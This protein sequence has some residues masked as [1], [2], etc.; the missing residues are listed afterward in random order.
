MYRPPVFR[1]DSVDA[2]RALIRDNPF[3]TLIVSGTGGLEAAHI[4]MVL[5]DDGAVG[6]LQGHVARPNPVWEI[7][8][9][10]VEALAVFQ[11]A[12][13]Y[14]TPS[15]YPSKAE[16]G[17]VVPT[18]NYDAVH[19]Y[20]TLRAVEDPD[21]LLEHLNAVTDHMEADRE[22]PWS[23]SDAPDDYIEKMMRG[24]VGLEI[25]IS[26]L[27]GKAKMS[28][29]RNATDRKGTAEGLRAEGTEAA[30]RVAGRISD[31]NK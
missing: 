24:L 18:W 16:H 26:R 28:Q 29:N 2:M 17:K 19:A 9:P 30:T 1:E 15:W 14:V 13:H 5:V 27:E 3:A 21:W 11:G 25:T 20:G 10:A 6:T 31:E 23:V 8:D 22:T 12:D 4:P 7:F